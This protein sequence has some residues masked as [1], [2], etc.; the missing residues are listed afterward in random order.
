VALYW[1][2]MTGIGQHVDVSK[3][4][5]SINLDRAEISLYASNGIIAK[6]V[7]AA[8]G[9]GFSA[10]KD[11]YILMAAADEHQWRTI[12]EIMGNPEWTKDERFKDVASRFQYSA[13]WAALIADWTKN[14][15]QDELFHK[16]QGAGVPCGVIRTTGDLIERDEQLK[17]RGFFTEIEHP[18][19]G[20]LT[21][22]SS[23]YRLSETPWAVERP[24]PLLGQHNEE[25][26]CQRLGYTR[27]ELVK[28]RE[29]GII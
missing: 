8:G 26:Y 12:V 29:A 21:Y 15:T 1:C 13:E 4:E 16:I 22:P 23:P 2:Q 9:I 27:E 28:M 24:A 20:R 18:M 10:C 3:Q 25:I 17:A 6:R 5:A 7:R 14:Y 11:G 19:A